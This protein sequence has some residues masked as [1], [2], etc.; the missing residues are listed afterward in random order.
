M[1]CWQKV[2]DFDEFFISI[3]SVHQYA[4]MMVVAIIPSDEDTIKRENKE[5]FWDEPS[6]EFLLIQSSTQPKD[7]G[8][9]IATAIHVSPEE[10]SKS[11]RDSSSTSNNKMTDLALASDYSMSSDSNY[12]PP[13][14][15]KNSKTRKKTRSIRRKSSGTR[16]IPYVSDHIPRR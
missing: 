8:D 16:K 14:V 11:H 3:E 10:E 6:D 2:K 4:S 9:I 1:N 5:P 13:Q 15:T 7:T 12:E